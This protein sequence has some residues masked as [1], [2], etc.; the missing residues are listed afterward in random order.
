MH[1][2]CHSYQSVTG[3]FPLL[4]AP[5]APHLLISCTD[6]SFAN[7]HRHLS[8]SLWVIQCQTFKRSSPSRLPVIAMPGPNLS[9]K[10]WLK[11]VCLPFV[12]DHGLLCR[13]AH[14]RPC[15]AL[16]ILLHSTPGKLTCLR[17]RRRDC[18]AL[19][20]LVNLIKWFTQTDCIAPGSLPRIW[21]HPTIH[22]FACSTHPSAIH[23][24]IFPFLQ[25][26]MHS[27]IH[28][29]IMQGSMLTC[30]SVNLP[31]CSQGQETAELTR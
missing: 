8:S 23:E 3:V 6:S 9:V 1:P 26:S 2:S 31:L 27:F 18:L 12:S 4:T 15:L 13:P 30:I 10:V 29:T 19:F 7:L 20:L 21:T 24:T 16:T 25:A 17:P 28:P 11:S 5:P 22:R 14:Y